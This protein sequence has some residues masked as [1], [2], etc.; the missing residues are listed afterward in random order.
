MQIY[1][2]KGLENCCWRVSLS[3][4]Q[5]DYQGRDKSGAALCVAS[6]KCKK[7]QSSEK[8]QHGTEPEG[9]SKVSKKLLD[10][11]FLW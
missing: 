3:K 6:R 9:W 4:T 5:T 11:Y 2:R 10:F 1:F 8:G 7:L